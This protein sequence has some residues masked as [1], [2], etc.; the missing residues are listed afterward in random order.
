MNI[1][2]I[3]QSLANFHGLAILL[4]AVWLSWKVASWK[5]TVD[6]RLTGVEKAI[7]RIEKAVETLTQRMDALTQRMDALTQ[8]MDTLTHKVDD[9]YRW[10]MNDSFRSIEKVDSPIAL[11]EYGKE[12]FYL[13]DAEKIV[14][15]YAEK[16]YN[17]TQEMNAYKVQEYCFTYCKEK[18]MDELEENDKEQSEKMALVAFDQGIDMERIT[19]IVGIALRDRVLQKGEKMYAEV[20]DRG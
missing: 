11:S 8:R 12:L 1:N 5:S 16:M 20:G 10:I 3:I 18:L 7:D 19:R 14:N 2:T 17:E 6:G 4:V 9:I 13:I 15:Q